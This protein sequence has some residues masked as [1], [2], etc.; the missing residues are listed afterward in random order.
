MNNSLNKKLIT[1]GRSPIEQALDKAR[2]HCEQIITKEY[3]DEQGFKKFP[4]MN[5]QGQEIINPRHT[6][7]DLHE[8]SD[9]RD[10]DDYRL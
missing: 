1:S 2:A 7:N 9:W 4:P 10:N 8:Q 5:T 6:P 3:Y